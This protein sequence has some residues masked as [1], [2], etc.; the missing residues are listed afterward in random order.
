[1]CV[2]VFFVQ[3]HAIPLCPPT[4]CLPVTRKCALTAVCVGQLG[5]STRGPRLENVRGK[6]RWAEEREPGEGEGEARHIHGELAW[7]LW[8]PGCHKEILPAETA[9]MS[10]LKA[11][12]V[13]VCV[14]TNTKEK[15]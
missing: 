1:M 5:S 10:A 13:T 6:E 9:I 11:E 3:M 15:C 7:L 14:R 12:V 2:C 8:E 4:T